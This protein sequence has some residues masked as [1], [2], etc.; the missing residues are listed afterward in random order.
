VLTVYPFF[1]GTGDPLE[2]AQHTLLLLLLSI[3]MFVGTT[4]F[5]F[6]HPFEITG[7]HPQRACVRRFFTSASMNIY[8]DPILVGLVS[9]REFINF[10]N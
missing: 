1:T 10:L 9:F 2:M 5:H 8:Q 7:H 6:I 4:L 3:S